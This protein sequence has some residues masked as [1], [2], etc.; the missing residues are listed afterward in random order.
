MNRGDRNSSKKPG[1]LN[2][3]NDDRLK[4]SSS[5]E[6][7]D[8]K[9]PK[10]QDQ[11]NRGTATTRGCRRGLTFDETALKRPLTPLLLV[12]ASLDDEVDISTAP[13]KT[14]SSTRKT[15]AG[16]FDMVDPHLRFRPSVRFI[17]SKLASI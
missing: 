1:R 7:R 14:L 3:G 6:K 10:Q 8:Q 12:S 9:N 11:M 2:K 16:S 17:A 15:E 5:D 13:K 4:G